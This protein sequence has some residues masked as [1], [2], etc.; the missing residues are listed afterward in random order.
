LG[1]VGNSEDEIAVTLEHASQVLS[2]LTAAQDNE[3]LVTIRR[4]IDL[5]EGVRTA[6]PQSHSNV[7]AMLYVMGSNNC[8]FWRLELLH[9]GVFG[10]GKAYLFIKK[11]KTLILLLLLLLLFF[12][13]WFP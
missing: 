3:Q 4:N 8:V 1:F 7:S 6:R 2:Q 13:S 9:H 11:N 12:S 10:I 5:M